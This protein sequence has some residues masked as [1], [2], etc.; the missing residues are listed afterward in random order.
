MSMI[1]ITEEVH[2]KLKEMKEKYAK[3]YPE[4]KVT[5]SF[6]IKKALDRLEADFNEKR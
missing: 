3:L 1:L 6:L 5:Y 2:R 4:L